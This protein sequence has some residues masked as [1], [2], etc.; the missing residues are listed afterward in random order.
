MRHSPQRKV[1]TTDWQHSNERYLETFL[2][3]Y[4]YIYRFINFREKKE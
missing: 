1:M 2:A 4:T 3:Q